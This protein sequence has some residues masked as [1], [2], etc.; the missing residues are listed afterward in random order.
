M[1]NPVENAR[2]GLLV[3]DCGPFGMFVDLES[4][5]A[6][7]HVMDLVMLADVIRACKTYGEEKEAGRRRTPDEKS[8]MIVR[9]ALLKR[10]FGNATYSS[11]KIRRLLFPT[12]CLCHYWPQR[13]CLRS[14]TFAEL[15]TGDCF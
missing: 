9:K 5:N 4:D 12:G 6:D 7:I 8:A 11:S 3:S 13:P 2:L 10:R 14:V 15:R 1:T